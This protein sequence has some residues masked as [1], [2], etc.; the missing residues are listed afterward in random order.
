MPSGVNYQAGD[1]VTRHVLDG[2]S[3]QGNTT[4]IATDS[5]TI[6]L[7]YQATGRL[8]LSRVNPPDFGPIEKVV[9]PGRTASKLLTN[10]E[11]KV[12]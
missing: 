8:E 12:E 2:F 6:H 5:A 10:I 7:S 1:F 9:S 3:F 11:V 4:D